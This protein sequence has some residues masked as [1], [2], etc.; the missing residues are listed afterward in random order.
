MKVTIDMENLQSI[1]EESAKIN[2]K[3]AVEQAIVDVKLR[4]S[5]TIRLL[6]MSTTILKQ[7]RFTSVEA[8][9]ATM[10]KNTQPKN[11]SKSK[12]KM[13]LRVSHLL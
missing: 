8:G 12:S 7:Q 11:I 4:K 3:N 2:T 5:L 9:T 13:C 6:N 1:I 10:L